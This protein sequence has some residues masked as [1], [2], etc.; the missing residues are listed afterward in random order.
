M[1]VLLMVL[2]EKIKYSI[3]SLKQS[4]IVPRD[5]QICINSDPQQHDKGPKCSFSLSLSLWG[6]NETQ[7]LH[8]YAYPLPST[9][10]FFFF[11]HLTF[12]F[13]YLV[14]AIF[15]LKIPFRQ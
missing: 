9:L 3:G 14:F 12:P 10:G 11:S 1:A 8:A 2:V 13:I 5:R 6:W 15:F 4:T 7:L